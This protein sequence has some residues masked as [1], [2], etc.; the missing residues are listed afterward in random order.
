MAAL[1]AYARMRRDFYTSIWSEIGSYDPIK[2]ALIS[3]SKEQGF[4]AN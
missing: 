4:N 2:Q 1:E 3:Y